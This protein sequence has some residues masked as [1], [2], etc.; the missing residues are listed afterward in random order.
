MS[1]Y[2]LVAAALFAVAGVGMVALQYL[3]KLPIGS[4]TPTPSKPSTQKATL[5]EFRR[6][7]K[8]LSEGGL[9]ESALKE[10]D[11]VLLSVIIAG[12]DQ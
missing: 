4:A 10:F 12:E 5:A 6:V 7:R 8:H 9:T 3:P 1:S 11:S 2:L